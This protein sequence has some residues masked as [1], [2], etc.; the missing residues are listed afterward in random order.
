MSLFSKIGSLYKGQS[1]DSIMDDNIAISAEDNNPFVATT[2]LGARNAYDTMHALMAPLIKGKKASL[3]QIDRWLDNWIE[4]LEA[5]NAMY[6]EI[7]AKLDD[8]SGNF[9]ATFTPDFL[10][11]AWEIVQDTPIL[12]RYMG[13]AN[14]WYLYDTLGLLATQAGSL[15]ADAKSGLK[16]MVRSAILALVSMTDGLLCLES[17]LGMIQQ[18][19]GALYLKTTDLPLLDSIVPNVTTAYWYKPSIPSQAGTAHPVTLTNAP[20]GKGFSPIPLPVPN[21]VMFT[22]NPAVLAS[23]DARN[24]DTWYL[25][26]TP[27]YMPNTMNLLYRALN[28]WGGSY[29]DEWLPIVN[30]IYP[31]RAYGTDGSSAPLQVGRT[32]AQLDTGR[33]E[34]AGT[35]VSSDTDTSRTDVFAILGKVFTDGMIPLADAWQSY[36]EAAHTAL[37]S[38]ILDGFRAYGESPSTITDF[39]ALQNAD[40]EGVY[41]KYATWLSDISNPLSRQFYNS[42]EGMYSCWRAM[43][44]QYPKDHDLGTD[45]S[46]EHALFDAMMRA[47]VDAGH[48]VSGYDGSLGDTEVY[49][50]APSSVP[51]NM[52]NVSESD[53]IAMGVPFVAYVADYSKGYVNNISTGADTTATGDLVNAIYP[54]ESFGCVM[55]PSDITVPYMYRERAL[56]FT[57]VADN[58]LVTIRDVTPGTA[59]NAP[60]GTEG[61]VVEYVY[62]KD[63]PVTSEIT[64][65]GP[66]TDALSMH[67]A[68]GIATAKKLGANA[69]SLGNMFFPTGEVPES[70]ETAIAPRTF[71]SLYRSFVQTEETGNLEMADIIGY[72]IDHGRET[73]FPCFGIYGDLLSMQSWH[74]REMP[75]SDFVSKYVRV[76]SGSSLYYLKSDPSKLVYY[77][78]SYVSASR[79]IQMAIYHDALDHVTKSYGSSDSYTF[80]VYPCESVSVTKL[81]DGTNLG[82]FL[83]VDAEGPDG[84]KY[85]YITM[86]NPIPKCAKYVD[87]RKWSVMDIVHEMYLLAYN[88]AGLCGDN[89][90]RLKDLESDLEEFHITAP[91]FVG[92]LPENNGQYVQFRFGIFQDYADRIEKLVNS[93][94]VLRDRIV[95]T[96]KSW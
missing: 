52:N 85:H 36:Y 40:T 39:W 50:S 93:V 65:V 38:Y 15:S 27:Y 31:R 58:M 70:E 88:L 3:K 69:I 73:K 78:S 49:V 26:G 63:I 81:P 20:P 46:A 90:E 10:R 42:V 56:P 96:T 80:Y 71:V 5:I 83:S 59:I 47:L 89:G 45:E 19:W 84:T 67:K 24:P 4:R 61:T 64:D 74:Y 60:V 87:P 44:A 6:A 29:T 53:S 54:V 9:D 51:N 48:A 25:D 23:F 68:A 32:F 11:E 33:M 76:N 2:V 30:N 34:L 21:P 8:V 22:R 35:D 95:A 37:T 79:Q 57:A 17:Y 28:Y 86:R 77:H 62:P 75:Y 43:V 13:E 66:L 72:A 18:Y 55:F 12:R 92:Q 7:L 16:E 91:R 1:S 82:N 14:Y 94:Y 41:P